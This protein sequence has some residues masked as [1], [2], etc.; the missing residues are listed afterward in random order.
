M[1][2]NEYK[3]AS[4]TYPLENSEYVL[5]EDACETCQTPLWEDHVTAKGKESEN[6]GQFNPVSDQQTMCT[7]SKAGLTISTW[8]NANEVIHTDNQ[9]PI[10]EDHTTQMEDIILI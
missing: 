3:T 1:K 6:T 8:Q 5:F 7:T 10:L 2:F 4:D 9:P